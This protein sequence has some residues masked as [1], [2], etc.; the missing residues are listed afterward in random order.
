MGCKLTKQDKMNEVNEER[1]KIF[2]T[3]KIPSDEF[4]CPNENCKYIPEI[5]SLQV[6]NKEIEFKCKRCGEKIVKSEDYQSKL[7]QNNYFYTE[8][9]Y[10]KSISKDNE[11]F[12]SYCYDCRKEFCTN[13]ECKRKHEAEHEKKNGKEHEN[14]KT[15]EKQFKIIK[16]NEKKKKCLRHYDQEINNYCFDCKANVCILDL[17]GHKTHKITK[18]SKLDKDL[19]KS[20]KIIKE[21]NQKLLRIIGFNEAILNS[22]D[23]HKNNYFYLKSLRNIYISLYRENQRDSKD[24]LFLLNDY[25]NKIKNSEKV[26]NRIFIAKKVN[27]K[28]EDDKLLF[29]NKKINNEDIKQLSQIK[30]NNLKEIHLS[31]NEITDIE[32]LCNISLPYLEL[33]NLSYNKIKNITPLGQL[34]T[35]KE[36]KYLFIQNNQIEDIQVFI[37]CYSSFKYLEILRLDENNIDENSDSYKA[38]TEKY[39]GKDNQDAKDIKDNIIITSSYINE[40]RKKYK[41]NYDLG[42]I[43]LKGTKESNLILRKLFIII[44]QKNQ[45]KIRK[46]NLS[47]NKIVDPSLL[48]RIQFDFLEELDLSLNQIKNLNFLERMNAKNLTNLLLD[49]NYINDLSPLEKYKKRFHHLNYISLKN[50]NFDFEQPKNK[51]I[52]KKLSIRN[53][54]S[55]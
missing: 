47:N 27:I 32:L 35:P 10:C 37:D 16:I 45:N 12:F 55:I 54:Y 2:Q 14:Q 22:F 19:K 46:L 36:F 53:D 34:N 28:R 51:L 48:N 15:K 3:E 17:K 4:L 5:L 24:L 18:L 50:N 8:C 38:F 39:D 30:F 31:G 52:L 11:D 23:K 6:D 41:I 42:E 9:I 25:E 7:E 21:K 13:E 40:I 1:K 43:E 20:K 44:T 29:N 33:L 49:N 26:S